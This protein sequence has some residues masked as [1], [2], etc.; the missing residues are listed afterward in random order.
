MAILG[1]LI[2]KVGADIEAFKSGMLSVTGEVDKM[3]KG[4][5][6]TLAPLDRMGDR[7]VS[8]GTTLTAAIT[9]P[10]AALGAASVKA[11]SDLEA[12]TMGLNAVTGSSAETEKQL[13]RLKEVAKLPGLGFEEAVQGTIR[14]QAAGF[15]ALE[16]EKALMAFGNA[17]ATVGKGR[18]E[19]DNV[20]TQLIQM[21]NKGKILSEDL[22]PLLSELP[23]LATTMKKTWGTID[24]EDLRKRGI[25][26]KEFIDTIIT[27]FGKMPKVADTFKNSMENLKDTLSQTLAEIGKALLP[28]AKELLNALTPILEWVK[29]AAK[30]FA[31]LPAPVKTFTIAFAAL[32]AAVGPVALA[33]GGIIT[34]ATSIGAVL[35]ASAL[36]VGGWAV[37]IAAAVAA[38]V[39]LGTWVYQNWEPIKKTLV[40]AFEGLVEVWYNLSW[41][42][43]VDLLMGAWDLLS[44]AV[45]AIWVPI[46]NFFLT[47][48]DGLGPSMIGVWDAIKGSLMAVWEGIKNAAVTA[49]GAVVSMFEKVVEW[50]SKIPGMDKLLNLGNTW[51]EAKKLQEQLQATTVSITATG[52]AAGAAGAKFTAKT[53][54]VNT[55]TDSLRSNGVELVKHV[56]YTHKLTDAKLKVINAYFKAKEASD[57]FFASVRNG[58]SGLEELNVM[59]QEHVTTV[60]AAGLAN[61]ALNT[62]LSGLSTTLGDTAIKTAEMSVDF[63]ELEN[64]LVEVGDEADNAKTRVEEFAEHA[65]NAV[66][67]MV[68]GMVDLLFG[69]GSLTQVFERAWK[70]I[71]RSAIDLF[72]D[73]IRDGIKDLVQNT[74]KS[75]LGK[76]GFGGIMDSIKGIG[77]SLGG[78]F[79]KGGGGGGGLGD[80]ALGGLMGDPGMFGGLGGGGGGGLGGLGSM[81]ALAG[82]PVGIAMIA[83]EAIKGVVQ[84]L[85]MARQETTLNA[86]EWNTRK[87][88]LHLEHTLDKANTEWPVLR[89]I[90]EVLWVIRQSIFEPVA[91]TLESML[92][93]MKGLPDAADFVSTQQMT[94]QEIVDHVDL[95]Y[96]SVEQ[97]GERVAE[98]VYSSG[99]STAV[100]VMESA[101]QVADAVTEGAAVTM[102]AVVDS[103]S[104]VTVHMSEQAAAIFG[105]LSAM[106]SESAA[107]YADL[108]GSL[109]GMPMHVEDSVKRGM[110]EMVDA[111]GNR[112]D[113]SVSGLSAKMDGVSASVYGMSGS[114]AAVSSRAMSSS[115]VSYTPTVVQPSGG[116]TVYSGGA[117]SGQ[118]GVSGGIATTVPATPSAT[119]VSSGS[120]AVS[121]P[122]GA[123]MQFGVG[124]GVVSNIYLSGAIVSTE[125]AASEVAAGIASKSISRAPF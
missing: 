111:V 91:S 10:I 71:A 124:K 60:A 101:T 65:G 30:A 42:P 122:S 35:G 5:E 113:A 38:L 6:K 22:K 116:G 84:G 51:S 19:L 41:K 82:G 59:V 95:M 21:A 63:G 89:D 62:S 29:V 109:V 117:R 66:A 112:V 114:L 108:K 49:W 45:Q 75:L 103:L 57:A 33:L 52:D 125:R 83:I 7:L 25:G 98:A 44:N 3:Q 78:L 46:K 56:E 81:A 23:Q 16:A 96:S 50:A 69:E 70:E 86:I 48:W 13:A 72:I 79:G 87:S 12:L 17:L 4:F 43:V 68:D 90:R 64:V 47:I 39:A 26:A 76:E 53:L 24:P 36:A 88:S 97:S 18:G 80:A 100:A 74:I 61:D 40:S 120:G 27:E 110:V 77:S 1:D 115:G 123:P 118:A 55:N 104:G 58:T 11:A 99:E 31:D 9:L 28:V 32:A 121:G 2:V 34:A 67:N 92:S 85:Q 94:T 14:L 54:A 119:P 105:Q 8:M 20:I 73:P 15:G 106:G 37:A 93:V 102:T 107:G